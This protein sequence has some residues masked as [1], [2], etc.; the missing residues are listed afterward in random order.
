[1]V[2]KTTGETIA[3]LH[4]YTLGEPPAGVLL[5]IFNSLQYLLFLPIVV[6]LYWRT[7]GGARLF[8]VVTAS[9]FFYMSWVPIYGILLLA[10]TSISW[11]LG[12]YLDKYREES[13]LSKLLLAAGLTLNL[14]CLCYYK[15]ANFI[16]RSLSDS[17]KA[18]HIVLPAI[19]A[20]DA[21]VLNIL[22]PLAISFFVFEF[23]HYLVDVYRG[24]KPVTSFM[25]FAAFAAFFPSQIA[26]PIKRYQEFVEQ[27][28]A[29]L[30]RSKA[31]FAEGL[32]LI[33]QGLF[34]KMAI[35]DPLGYC[36]RTGFAPGAMM[37]AAD[38]LI[39][40]FGFLIQ[41]YCD[42]SGYT[43]IGRGSALLLG[44]RLPENF[45]LPYL[46]F[47][48]A[49]FWRRW[50]MSLSTW[51]RDYLYIPMGGSRCSQLVNARNL[52]VT[53][54][55]CGL[56]HGADWH[57]I[58]FGCLH[59]VGLILNR[60]WKNTLNTFNGLKVLCE[61]KLGLLLSLLL[62]LAYVTLGFVIFRAPSMA[63]VGNIV[64]SLTNFAQP[65]TLWDLVVKSGLP[66]FAAVYFSL[67]I[68]LEVLKRR[69][70]VLPAIYKHPFGFCTPVKMA[71]WTAAVIFMIA[72][73]PIEATPFIYFQF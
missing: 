71:A 59:G 37:S 65:C 17:C 13:Q 51:L 63:Q 16:L 48:L 14:G 28:K 11:I 66:Q 22:L 23:V 45:Q 25:E 46:S 67:W 58:M 10:L 52:F 44:I 70:N 73:K 6:F 36:I 38:A 47:D 54:A 9:Y 61:T 31:L 49:D 33:V 27:L 24:D 15:Y 57:F 18:F 69:P 5:M 35:A 72:A 21:P 19:P 26:G 43:D 12:L 1:M 32:T 56:W 40:S 64:T 2:V 60:L 20:W 3:S 34:K 30:P 7:K 42:F 53:M 4:L 39:V 55:V 68:L 41:L 8:L 29:P 50:H 62:T